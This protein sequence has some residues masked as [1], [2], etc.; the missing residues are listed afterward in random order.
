MSLEKR[1]PGS[2]LEEGKSGVA[3]NSNH[4]GDKKNILLA[5]RDTHYLEEL[6][7]GLNIQIKNA[8]SK[9]FAKKAFL[10]QRLKEVEAEL[11]QRNSH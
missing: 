5:E 4:F 9:D 10:E 7:E 6:I 8:D 1:V 11:M 2:F 3:S